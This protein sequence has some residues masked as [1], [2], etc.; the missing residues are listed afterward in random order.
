MF[1]ISY[2]ERMGIIS[3]M[4]TGC[5]SLLLSE[6]HNFAL[7]RVSTSRMIIP[8]LSVKNTFLHAHEICLQCFLRG[9]SYS[10]YTFLVTAIQELFLKLLRLDGLKAGSCLCPGKSWISIENWVFEFQTASFWCFVLA[11]R[12]SKLAF[13]DATFIISSKIRWSKW[14]CIAIY[15]INL[16]EHLLENVLR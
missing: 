2:S 15:M 14:F 12:G 10:Q 6:S 1:G 13:L 9:T 7:G 4:L 16:N 3:R 11:L 8:H 5:P